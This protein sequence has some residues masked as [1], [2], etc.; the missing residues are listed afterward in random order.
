MFDCIY[1]R[2]QTHK[3]NNWELKDKFVRMIGGQILI[4]QKTKQKIENERNTK[5]TDICSY[6]IKKF[7]KHKQ[8]E[9]RRTRCKKI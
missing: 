7:K 3:K 9:D 2:D 1:Q 6:Q 4:K 5:R 8:K